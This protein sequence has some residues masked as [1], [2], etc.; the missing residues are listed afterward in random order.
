MKGLSAKI[1]FL[2][3]KI[4]LSGGVGFVSKSKLVITKVSPKVMS[5]IRDDEFVNLLIRNV[6]STCLQNSQSGGV[7]FGSQPIGGAP[8]D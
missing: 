1:T 5:C 6:I 4:R 7:G 3:S 8:A 2:D